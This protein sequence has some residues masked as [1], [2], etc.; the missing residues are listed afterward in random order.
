[1]NVWAI[2][3]AA[4]QSSRLSKAGLEAKKQFLLWKDRPLFWHSARTMARVPQIKGGVFVFPDDEYDAAAGQLAELDRRDGLGLAW[5]VVVGGE[6]RQDSVYNGLAA[7]PHDCD[8]VLVHDAARPFF[9]PA[10]AGRLL[11]A[12]ADGAR[13]VIPA[14]LVKDTIK[15]VAEN[16]VVGTPR[17]QELVAVQTPQAFALDLLRQSHETAR[18]EG[19]EVTDDASMVEQ[20]GE[21]VR[22]VPGEE[23]NL[24]ITTPEDLNMLACRSGH[25]EPALAPCCG[26]GYDVHRYATPELPP[27]QS[28]PLKLG[29]VLIPNGP[30]ILAHSDGDALLHALTDALLGCL[31]QGDIGQRFPD[32][33]PAFENM[34]SA[35]FLN[36]V[37]QDLAPAGVTLTHV[38]L[39][40]VAQIPKLAPW[41]EQIRQ[42]IARLLK[43]APTQVNVKATTEEGL[44]FTGEKK[45]IKAVAAVVGLKP[46]P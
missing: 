23:S 3:L 24:K 33:D 42:N 20:L 34:N 26:W 21:P 30:R 7:L 10:L 29:G 14:I 37:I 44:G 22:V 36:E 32:T 5:R 40:I 38:D 19:W 2:I 8:Y 16:R 12:L 41:R 11:D 25:N 28:R 9:S 45:G 1:M 39:T 27:E 35:I 46:T 43:L 4:G 31:G 17:R 18:R 15:Q 13:A 6:R